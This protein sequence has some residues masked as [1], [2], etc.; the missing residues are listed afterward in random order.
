MSA[1]DWLRILDG[2]RHCFRTLRMVVLTLASRARAEA[3]TA[4]ERR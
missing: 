3:D 4:E 2:F 1:I